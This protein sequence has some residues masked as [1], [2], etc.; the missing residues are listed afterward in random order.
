MSPSVLSSRALVLC[1][2]G[3]ALNMA[4]GQAVS[5]LNLPIFLDSLGTVVA[6]VLCGPVIGGLTGLLTNL[7]WG[8]IQ[9][10]TAAFFAPVALVVGVAAG[11]LARAGMF[12][13][14]WRA[15]VA[16]V[17]IAVAL[18]VVAVP[19]R[20]FLFGGVTGSGADFAVAYL[21]KVGESLFGS[22]LVTVIGSNIIDKVAT[23]VLAWAI[24]RGLPARSLSDW[25][26]LGHSRA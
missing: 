9:G 3:I 14:W 22:V 24:L 26:Y 17:V 6:A 12:R 21:L 20:I 1:A 15:A 19:I 13:S 2:I 18:S 8:L 16:G 23:A 10:P 4:L 5:F 11:L 7:I 25:P